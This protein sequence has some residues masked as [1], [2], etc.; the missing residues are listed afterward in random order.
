MNIAK[1]IEFLAA[2]EWQLTIFIDFWR[3]GFLHAVFSQ[4]HDNDL[5]TAEVFKDWEKSADEPMGKGN[6][7][8]D[9]LK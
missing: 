4:L 9:F 8:F 5:V 3:I 2:A 6:V 1:L 7:F